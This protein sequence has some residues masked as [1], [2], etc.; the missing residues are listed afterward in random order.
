MRENSL[1]LICLTKCHDFQF[2]QFSSKKL[3]LFFFFVG[4]YTH[5]STRAHTHIHWEET[6]LTL[7]IALC[8]D[9]SDMKLSLLYAYFYG[10]L[11]IPT[12]SHILKSNLLMYSLYFSVNLDIVQML[13]WTWSINELILFFYPIISQ[14]SH[15]MALLLAL[16]EAPYSVFHNGWINLSFN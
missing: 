10:F 6:T 5:T 12:V 16:G 8:C 7:L 11:Y 15:L 4:K 1:S 2:L 14:L 9:S 3:D 13:M